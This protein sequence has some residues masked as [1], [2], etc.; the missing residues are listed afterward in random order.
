MRPGIGGAFRGACLAAV[1]ILSLASAN[2]IQP[3]LAHAKPLRLRHGLVLSIALQKRTFPRNALVRVRAQVRNAGARPVHLLPS[4][5]TGLLGAEVKDVSGRSL[6]PPAL[7]SGPEFR[8]LPPKPHTLLPGR[9]VTRRMYVILRGS[10]VRAY[11]NLSVHGQAVVVYG[12]ALTV[13]LTH[14]DSP[15][16]VV[17]THPFASAHVIPPGR[18]KG[19]MHFME[20]ERCPLP[21]GSGNAI[22]DATVTPHWM[23]APRTTARGR[24]TLIA[25]CPAP[26]EWDV[27]AGWI[28]HSVVTVKETPP[29]AGS[30]TPPLTPR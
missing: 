11:V 19:N 18:W 29:T 22:E 10:R 25:P 21:A 30:N 16:L 1:A 7:Q 5:P 26:N 6:Y 13:T 20:A 27:V 12:S 24:V 15:H 2:A 14:P 28:G 8:C 17:N 23:T 4:C 3:A 9:V